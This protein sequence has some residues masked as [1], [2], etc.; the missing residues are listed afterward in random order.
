[1]KLAI[2][3]H[4][5][6]PEISAASRRISSLQTFLEKNGHETQVFAPIKKDVKKIIGVTR[7][8]SCFLLM[9]SLRDF[10]VVIS[11]YYN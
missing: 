4:Y 6:S 11:L 1:M 2:T 5:A 3:T 7:F 9:K 10:D 8:G